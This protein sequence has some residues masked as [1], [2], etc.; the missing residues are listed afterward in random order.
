LGRE[1][2][3]GAPRVLISKYTLSEDK[4]LAGNVVTLK[5]SIENTHSRPVSNIKVSLGIVMVDNTASGSGSS[6]SGGTVFSPVNSSNSFFIQQI[7]ARTVWEHSVD[8][9]VDPNAAAKTYVVPVIIE[10]DD[11]DAKPYKVE[12][13]VNI[14]VTQESRLQVLSI[15]IPPMAFMGQPVFVSAEF[16]NV[17]KVD[18]GNFIVMMEGNFPKELASYFVGNLGIGSSDYYQGIIYP[19]REGTLEGEL[20][21]SYIDNNNREVQVVEPFTIEVMSMGETEV[22]PRG[23]WDGDRFPGGDPGPGGFRGL[24]GKWLWLIILVVVAGGVGGFLLHRMAA[25]KRDAEFSRD[26]NVNNNSNGN[27]SSS[28]SNNEF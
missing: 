5:L 20:I 19:D 25:K 2:A 26:D 10:Y 14:P 13:I 7:P 15:E 9:L 17:G 3:T 23:D 18:L 8:L 21:F 16:V 24:I 28:N 4:I 1:Y 22:F 27:N 11:E 6:S 12:E